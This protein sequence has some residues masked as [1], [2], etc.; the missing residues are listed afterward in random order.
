MFFAVIFVR[1]SPTNY[2]CPCMISQSG[3]RIEL[4][5]VNL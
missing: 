4:M 2:S 1:I 3:P 5:H